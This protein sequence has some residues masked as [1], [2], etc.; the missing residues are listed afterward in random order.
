[1]NPPPSKGVK[2]K[3]SR[4]SDPSSPGDA[5]GTGLTAKPVSPATPYNGNPSASTAS[6]FRNSNGIPLPPPEHF[7]LSYK[8]G[9]EQDVTSEERQ[10][11]TGAESKSANGAPAIR[12][13]TAAS[14]EKEQNESEGMSHVVS[15]T[16]I[17]SAQEASGPRYLGSASGISFARV[18]F[19]AVKSSVPGHSSER[20]SVR[21]GKPSAAAAASGT[22]MRDSF[23]RLHTKP[24]VRQAPFPDRKLGLRLADLY[25]EHANP[26]I[27]ILHRGEFMSLFDRAYAADESKKTPRE[28]Y[29]LNIVF[30]I[31]AGIIMD[32]S[33]LTTKELPSVAVSPSQ[34]SSPGQSHKRAK[35]EI[36][37]YQPEEYHALAIVHLE[38]FLG[39]T[40]A[41]DRSD[42]FGDGL[43]ALQ[44]VLLLAGFALLRP[45]APGLWYIIGVAVRLGVDLGLHSEGGAEIDDTNTDRTS[46][47]EHRNDNTEASDYTG[48]PNQARAPD[49]KERGRR[50][51]GITDQVI[52]T[53]FPSLLDDKYITTAGFQTPPSSFTEIPSYKHVSHHYFRLR[54]LQSEILQVLQH[55]QVQQARAHGANQGNQFMHTRLASPFLQNF[56]SFREWRLD[57][58]RRLWEWKE[59]APTQQV[60]GVQ[61]SPLFLELNYWQAVI[62]LY[63]QSLSV[64]PVLAGEM[65][66]AKENE[67]VQSPGMV[68][69]E[70]RDDE[71]TVFLKVAEA[72]Q[73]V[74]KLYRQLHRVRL[75]NYTFLATHHLFMAGISFLYA[76]WHSAVVR[77]H[78]S[79]DDVDFTVLAAT[80]VLGDLVP[81]C[82]PAEACRDAFDRM[83]K[84]TIQMCL[85]TTGFGEQAASYETRRQ[86]STYQRGPYAPD[87]RGEIAQYG[88]GQGQQT[89]AS[90]Q[91]NARRP[92]PK[93][94]MNLGDLFPDRTSSSDYQQRHRTPP[95]R[96]KH[97][98]ASAFPTYPQSTQPDVLRQQ[99]YPPLPH[100]ATSPGRRADSLTTDSTAS[101]N[102]DPT[103]RF[104]PQSYCHLSIPAYPAPNLTTTTPFRA[105]DF[106][107]NVTFPPDPKPAA[108]PHSS[109]RPDRGALDLDLGFGA[110]GMAWD[111]SGGGGGGGDGWSEGG[112]FDLFDGFFFG[113]GEGNGTNNDSTDT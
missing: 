41:A 88:H 103:L 76:I 107:T 6:S 105:L 99:P 81:K 26:Q 59:T 32:S 33:D 85:S 101:A 73:R 54:L 113:G 21:P 110:G 71:E 42:G 90:P 95:H 98:S 13:T 2:R 109:C 93:F 69:V 80:S 104:S 91:K 14:K 100:L 31:G 72:G 16:G 18:V 48:A 84:A 57:I 94:D 1:M 47:D 19:A 50:P 43:E 97:D 106:L 52:T 34:S 89:H 70:E 53:E 11:S 65:G 49:A 17:V 82:P 64:P 45:V 7:T 39:S 12:S 25:F 62:M 61:F 51:F 37:Q 96:F 3:Q 4:D 29:M 23:F 68:N 22:S 63:R 75:V 15:D 5:T 79:L 9:S 67:E 77:S 27:P 30:A 74:L 36:W 38:S 35:L 40:S 20:G 56:M 28:A 44:A 24:T 111:G 102:I 60:T 112:G 8:S 87:Q 66:E 78:L 83:S 86:G 108:S 92:R 10:N 55:R 46:F 58:D